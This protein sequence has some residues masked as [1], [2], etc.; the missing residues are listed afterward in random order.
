MVYTVYTYIYTVLYGIY[1]R[2]QK[3]HT[4]FL[5]TLVTFFPVA[6]AGH[7]HAEHK[8]R[9][10]HAFHCVCECVRVCMGVCLY[11]CVCLCVCVCV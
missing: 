8:A 5:P 4:W 10:E 1:I 2:K 9:G 3:T 6:N 11:L 7:I